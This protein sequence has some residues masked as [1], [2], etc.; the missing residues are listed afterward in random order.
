MGTRARGKAA[1]TYIVV[2]AGSRRM[3]TDETVVILPEV[4]D[5]MGTAQGQI[6][7]CILC[8]EL[9]G[10]HGQY[11]LW[12]RGRRVVGNGADVRAVCIWVRAVHR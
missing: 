10:K 1:A 4:C 2:R 6:N 5:S 3:M 11:F 8:G 9:T 7:T 12:G